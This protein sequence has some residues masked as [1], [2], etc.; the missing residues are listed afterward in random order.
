MRKRKFLMLVLALPALAACASSAKRRTDRELRGWGFVVYH[1]LA[2]GAQDKY[3]VKGTTDTGRS[4]FGNARLYERNSAVSAYGGSRYQSFPR[5]VRVTWREGDFVLDM[6]GGW[7]GGTIV[8]DYTVPVLERIPEELFT[9][10]RAQRGRAI[11]LKFR[12]H[13]GGVLFGWD[14]EDHGKDF[15]GPLRHVMAGGDW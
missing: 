12:I 6:R 11:R 1:E 13:D 5:W 7:K 4:I 10:V 2:P 9:Y 14:V 3:G 8:G 15:E